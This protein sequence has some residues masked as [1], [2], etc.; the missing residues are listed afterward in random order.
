LSALSPLPL[1]LLLRC[2]CCMNRGREL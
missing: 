1:L 2:P